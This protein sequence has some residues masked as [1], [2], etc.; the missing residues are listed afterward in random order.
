MHGSA[1]ARGC[2]FRLPAYRARRSGGHPFA[3]C[4]RKLCPPTASVRSF[5]AAVSGD[6][7][8]RPADTSFALAETGRFASHGA[9]SR[10]SCPVRGPLRFGYAPGTL[11]RLHA[12]RSRNRESARPCFAALAGAH[13]AF[14]AERRAVSCRLTASSCGQPDVHCVNRRCSIILNAERCRKGSRTS[15]GRRALGDAC[16]V[17]TTGAPARSG[18][19]S[20]L[21]SPAC[22]RIKRMEARRALCTTR[23]ARRR[24]GA[25]ARCA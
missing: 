7:I 3:S 19:A 9:P 25:G 20:K 21:C 4:G 17:A 16:A 24:I 10:T 2:R 15:A 5:S 22:S 18:R 1:P 23:G 11:E 13:R 6:A 8:M 14:A 12:A